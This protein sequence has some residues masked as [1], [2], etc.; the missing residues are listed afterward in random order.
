MT[1]TPVAARRWVIAASATLMMLLNIARPA[2]AIRLLQQD[3]A[4]ITAPTEG[5]TLS[6]VVTITGSANHPSF[7]RYELAYGPDPNPNDAWQVFVTNQ[8]PLENGTLGAWN[9]GIIADGAYMLRLRVVRKDSNYSEAF[10]RGL[11]ISNS[12]PIGT[13]TSLPP[14]PTFPAEQPTFSA[15]PGAAAAPTAIVIDLPPTGTPAPIADASNPTTNNNQPRR[16]G[17]SAAPFNTGMIV[18]TCFT[19]VLLAVGTFAIVGAI[20]FGRYV[21]KQFLRYRRKTLNR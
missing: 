14:A 13:P 17:G 18:S 10:V 21:Y 5:Q 12:Q 7:D 2:Q 11:R 4:A 15:E 19:G 8:Q 16:S 3:I 20:Q 9:T 1:L 6:G